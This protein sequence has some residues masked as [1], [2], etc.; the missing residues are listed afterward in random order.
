MR[1]AGLLIRRWARPLLRPLALGLVAAGAMPLASPASAA[2]LPVAPAYNPP[3]AYIPALYRWSGIYL[4]G[5]LGVGILQDTA[6]APTLGFASGYN[7]LGVTGGGQI[8]ADIQF[9]NLVLGV[10]GNWMATSISGTGTATTATPGTSESS[11]SAVNWLAAATGRVGYAFNNHLIYG[12][13]GAAWENVKYTGTTLTTGG[14]V[15][16]GASLSDT[17]T[18]Y[19]AGGGFE[20][21]FTEHF[22]GKIEYDYYG[23]GSKTY[24]FAGLNAGA[25][26]PVTIKSNINVLL[27]GISYRFN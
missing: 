18:G 8:G 10:E 24:T 11:T 7:A 9:S 1:L 4:G 17:R 15:N 20:L 21:G 27:L 16:T 23:F 22:S 13:G 26:L 14:G 19:V 12:K 2:D 3:P 25:N 6:A 5:N